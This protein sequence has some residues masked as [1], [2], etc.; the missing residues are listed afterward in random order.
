MFFIILIN[1]SKIV[2]AILAISLLV[3]Y[4]Y[5]R[6]Q[7]KY[8]KARNVPYIKPY[9]PFGNIT[10]DVTKSVNVLFK[11]LY[12]E[13]KH[14]KYCGV[15]FLFKPMLMVNDP[16]L[17][18]RIFIKNFSNFP[19]GGSYFDKKMDPFSGREKPVKNL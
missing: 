17:I 6:K 18:Q 16:D 12:D 14:H 1:I 2:L 4:F 7:Y 9:F 8:W 13:T 15:W 19:A 3:L 11:K 10:W 5:F